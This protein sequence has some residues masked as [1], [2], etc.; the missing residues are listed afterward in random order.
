LQPA[1]MVQNALN[2]TMPTV[3]LQ[4]HGLIT[5]LPCKVTVQQATALQTHAVVFVVNGTVIEATPER[6]AQTEHGITLRSACGK[7]HLS[8]VEHAL[9]ACSLLG[10]SG[11]VFTVEG[12]PELP[13]LDGS[14]AEWAEALKPFIPQPFAKPPQSQP[15]SGVEG[16][17]LT[18][19]HAIKV[20]GKGNSFILA[21]P[22]PSNSPGLKLTY[23]LE[24]PHALTQNRFASWH[25]ASDD[26]NRLLQARTFGLTS[27]LPVLQAKGLAKGVTLQNTLGLNPDGQTTTT[28]LRFEE[29]PL[30]HKMLDLL[31][32]FY[33]C[34]LPANRLA[35]QLVAHAAGHGLHV[36]LAKRLS[37][38][39][40]QN[41]NLF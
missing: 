14:A 39:F 27:D 19:K 40:F 38:Y 12:A 3:T 1:F 34:G 5:G 30:Y 16:S 31:G 8:I 35:M 21:L 6:I 28:P 18:L 25:A 10:L 33:L 29:E 4:G 22:S 17:L 32:D 36:E 2:K 7:Q 13:L 23:S 37:L 20:T 24:F 11:L 41:K 26:P 9:G 15:P